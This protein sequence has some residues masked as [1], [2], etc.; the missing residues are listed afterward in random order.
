MPEGKLRKGKRNKKVHGTCRRCGEKAFHL[1]KGVCASCGFGKSK[2]RR[3][4]N[5]QKNRKD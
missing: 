4:Y 3:D 2:K 5:W 1:K